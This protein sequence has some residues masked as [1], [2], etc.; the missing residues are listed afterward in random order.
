M[1]K[2]NNEFNNLYTSSNIVMAMKI[3]EEEM[4]GGGERKK[5]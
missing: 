4:G 1:E 2:M 5:K 3:R